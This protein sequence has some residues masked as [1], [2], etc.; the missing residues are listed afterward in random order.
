MRKC[1]HNAVHADGRV[2]KM[3]DLCAASLNGQ[4]TDLLKAGVVSLRVDSLENLL[5]IVGR[6]A[7]SWQG[8]R[9]I[10]PRRYQQN[11]RKS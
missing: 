9:I 3:P 1:T 7:A 10:Q 8:I 2:Y 6:R 4:D 11:P 5:D